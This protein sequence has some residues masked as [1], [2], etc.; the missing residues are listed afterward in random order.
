MIEG[1]YD[2]LKV[3]LE[4]VKKAW[5]KSPKHRSELER[6]QI[7]RHVRAKREA[8]KII[9]SNSVAGKRVSALGR[10]RRTP[11]AAKSVP[12]DQLQ[13]ESYL[14]AVAREYLTERGIS[15]N[16]IATW[17]LGWLDDE[18]RIAIPA[19]DENMRLKFLIKRAIREKDQP[20]YLYTEGFPKTALLFGAGQI[21]RGMVSS[22]GLIV[23]EGSVDTILNHQDGYRNTVGILGTGISDLQCR[24][25]ARI[26]PPRI[27][28]WF[29]KDDA[30]VKNIQIAAFKLRKYPM[31][32]AR[33]PKGKSD[34]AELTRREKEIQLSRVIPLV[35]F[36]RDTG[37]SVRRRERK[38]EVG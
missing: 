31:Y 20:K 28:L 7:R 22:H 16:S 30:G 13:Y 32:V 3:D 37:L 33:F 19:Y 1:I 6:E 24:I 8:R 26:R 27:I 15:A 10:P 29:D 38:M 34:P 18:R 12:R 11:V 2:R 36:V 17:K 25:V 23:V 4:T 35:K 21:D 5:D 9:L 14:P